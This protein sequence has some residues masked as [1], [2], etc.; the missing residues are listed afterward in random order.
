MKKNVF[1]PMSTSQV[2]RGDG[3][4]Q[5]LVALAVSFGCHVVFMLFFVVTP[6]FRSEPAP[7]QSVINVSMVSLRQPAAANNDAPAVA[8]KTPKIEKPETVKPVSVP[9][10]QAKP[11][12]A[13]TAPPP[14]QPKTSLKKQTFKSTQVVKR[15]TTIAGVCTANYGRARRWSSRIQMLR[16]RTALACPCRTSGSLGACGW[17]GLIA[18]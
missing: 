10:R 18:R 5:W 13:A 16:N 17:H 7:R 3:Q 14:P 2:L 12:D 11:A 4:R 6:G 1:T 9:P 8:T 15:A